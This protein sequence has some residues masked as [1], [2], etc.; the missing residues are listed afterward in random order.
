AVTYPLL[1]HQTITA[2]ISGPGGALWFGL[3]DGRIV[4]EQHGELRAW[5]ESDGLSGGTIHGLSI[6]NGNQL[7]VA[8]EHGLCFLG[9]PR[10]ACRKSTSGL[11]GDRVLWALPDAHESLWLAYP[12]GVGR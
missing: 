3:A 7:W 9:G 11:P 6:G 2:M 10:F 5:S 4:E 12:I 1:L 8:T